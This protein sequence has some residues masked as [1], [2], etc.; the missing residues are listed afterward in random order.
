MRFGILS[1]WLSPYV[2]GI[3]DHSVNLA[4]DLRAHGHEVVLIGSLGNAAEGTRIV[5]DDWSPA[6]LER[7]RSGLESMQLDHLVMQYTPLM[8]AQGSWRTAGA[9]VRFWQAL[10]SAM[11]PSLI[12]HETY[13]R[14]WRRPQSL[15]RGTGEKRAL[16]AMCRVSDH[17]FT[18]SGPLLE[19]MAGWGLKR[20]AVMLPISSNI[21]VAEADIGEVRARHGIAPGTLVLT[22]FGGGNNLKWMLD[23][24]VVL[25]R[26][27]QVERI[28]HAWLLLGGVPKSWLS[29]SAAVL[30]PGCL[31]QPDL[32]E[33]LQMTDIFLMPNWSGVNAKRGTLMAAL[34]HG[35]PVIG[36]R[37]HMT[38]AFWRE[39]EGVILVEKKSVAG[40]VDAVLTLARDRQM[41]D[42]CGHLNK[43]YFRD[44]FTRA[45]LMRCFL[46]AVQGSETAR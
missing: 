43:G 9:L 25:E 34:E 28:P 11:T 4:D 37:G 40:F 7:L 31:S 29:S 26:R 32:S 15:L 23:H 46:G 13:F 42:W 27:L 20:P 30:D 14:T 21:P 36:T 19:E 44:R 10:G 16:K 2:G 39:A 45:E 35:L 1:R 33:N 8:Y 5:A 3:V 18:A 17:V 12:V 22:L 24:V 41:R 38:D 6:A